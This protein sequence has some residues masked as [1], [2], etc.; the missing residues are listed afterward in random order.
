VGAE[1]HRTKKLI[2]TQAEIVAGQLHK[3]PPS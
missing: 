3:K 2:Q 1:A